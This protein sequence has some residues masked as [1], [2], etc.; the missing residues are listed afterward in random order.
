MLEASGQFG[1]HLLEVGQ[2]ERPPDLLIG[3]TVERI[4]VEAEGAGEEHGV[5]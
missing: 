1:G 2:F 3:A 5:L 4:E